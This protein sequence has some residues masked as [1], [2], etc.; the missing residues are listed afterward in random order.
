QASGQPKADRGK[1]KRSIVGQATSD[2]KELSRRPSAQSS[3]VSEKREL[4]NKSQSSRKS[5]EK[6]TTGQAT[7]E[8]ISPAKKGESP[9]ASQTSKGKSERSTTGQGSPDSKA[10]SQQNQTTGAATQSKSSTQQ[11]GASIRSRA[12]VQVSAQQ[13]TTI[14]QS[15]LSARNVPRVDRVNFAIRTGTVVPRNVHIVSVTTFPILIDVFPRYRNYS[16]FVVEDEIIFVDRGYRIVDIVPV[17]GGARL[18]SRASTTFVEDLSEDEIREIQLVL[19]R[20]GF[21][22]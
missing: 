4:K 9:T 11:S 14:Q 2:K 18:S 1:T 21:L 5:G 7:R 17:G 12:G 22:H 19:I 16:F 20:R 13:Q 8:K 3:K 6:V 15:V 10:Q